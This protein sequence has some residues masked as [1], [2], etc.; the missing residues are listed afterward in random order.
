MKTRMI[1]FVF[2]L[3]LAILIFMAACTNS[4]QPQKEEV[5]TAVSIPTPTM[6]QTATANLLPTPPDD[7]WEAYTVPDFNLSLAY[8]VGWFVHEAG[9]ALQI[10]P[11]AQPTW[12][13]Y[14]DPNEPHGGPTFDLLYNLN[15]LMGPT[16]LA[17]VENLLQGY[18]A[19]IDVM[20]AAAPL[21]DR[22]DVVVGVYRFT[23]EDD[24]MA[25]LVGAVGNPAADSPQSVIAMTGL[26][27][28]DELAEMQPIFERILRSLRPA[29]E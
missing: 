3:F 21:A 20:E 7:G 1:R 23:V 25:L 4:I 9:K 14:F 10:T 18:E 26:V 13:S 19:D 17:E 16:P 8:P 12:S 6:T 2:W 29:S 5:E 11:N 28:T 22:P 24:T 27:K 15:R